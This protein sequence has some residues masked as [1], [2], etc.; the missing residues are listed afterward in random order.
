[1]TMIQSSLNDA[2]DGSKQAAKPAA[3]SRQAEGSLRVSRLAGQLDCHEPLREMWDVHN[4][5]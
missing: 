2:D 4:L 5:A 1:M 3:T